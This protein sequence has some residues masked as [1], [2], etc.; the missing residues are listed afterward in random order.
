M[1]SR[2]SVE[3]SNM[4]L[5]KRERNGLCSSESFQLI[6]QLYL[7]LTPFHLHR[8]KVSW[9]HPT[10][11][12]PTRHKTSALF[13]KMWEHSKI[14][15]TCHVPRPKVVKGM[16]SRNHLRKESS[17]LSAPA[18]VELDCRPKVMNL[19]GYSK[20]TG[21]DKCYSAQHYM[22]KVKPDV[23]VKW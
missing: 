9:V 20:Y 4:Y 14:G 8:N 2:I 16:S 15:C 10:T 21:Q 22:T 11:T 17:P 12:N 18:A 5:L 3:V 19:P 1:C 13:L 7:P 6:N 23:D